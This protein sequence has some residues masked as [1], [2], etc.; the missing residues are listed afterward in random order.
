M[1]V[2]VII[3]LLFLQDSVSHGIEESCLDCGADCLSGVQSAVP[4]C[5]AA[6]FEYTEA[7]VGCVQKVLS[8]LSRCQ[9][10]IKSLVC[11]VTDSCEFCT[12]DCNHLLRFD[13]P[14]YS[15]AVQQHSWL[16]NGQCHFAFIGNPDC[17]DCDGKQAYKSVNCSNEVYLHYH[18]YI[19]DGR[20]VITEGLDD[21]DSV[22]VLRNLGDGLDDEECPEKD[23]KITSLNATLHTLLGEMVV[24]AVQ[25]EIASIRKEA[26]LALGCFCLRSPEDARTHMLLLLQAP[27]L[28]GS[29]PTPVPNTAPAQDPRQ[30]HQ[31]NKRHTASVNGYTTKD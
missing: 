30:P 12:C 8:L 19:L 31:Q 7:L 14:V 1:K 2:Y 24:V 3:C 18:D 25:S 27:A 9:T 20:W 15:P 28:D 10:C 4:I 26:I 6:G 11:C 17:E 21:D 5:I 16:F 29:Q 13:A 22:A 23:P